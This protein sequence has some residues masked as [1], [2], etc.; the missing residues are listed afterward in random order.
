M[1]ITVLSDSCPGLSMMKVVFSFISG[2]KWNNT[3]LAALEDG[4][5]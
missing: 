5:H 3:T 4:A 1:E 2:R